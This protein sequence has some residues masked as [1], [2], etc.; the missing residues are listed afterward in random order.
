MAIGP[1]FGNHSGNSKASIDRGSSKS[2]HEH[3]IVIVSAGLILPSRHRLFVAGHRGDQASSKSSVADLA[4]PS[5]LADR[6]I[7]PRR[8]KCNLS[9]YAAL[10]GGW[11]H[12]SARGR[13]FLIGGDT[14]DVLHRGSSL[15]TDTEL[16]WQFR[17]PLYHMMVRI[18]GAPSASCNFHSR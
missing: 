1:V 13:R 6:S 12:I 5:E 11:A 18:Q 3:L 8:D 15:M 4:I 16:V 2:A 7:V 17:K 10:L 14:C 9:F